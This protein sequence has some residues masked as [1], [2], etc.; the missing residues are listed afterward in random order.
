MRSLL[1]PAEPEY[2]GV[3][4]IELGIPDATTHHPGVAQTVGRGILFALGDNRGFIA[5]RTAAGHIRV[6]VM[7][8]QASKTTANIGADHG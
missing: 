3:S 4:A 6:Y 5:Q 7:F 2:C 1:T 8:R